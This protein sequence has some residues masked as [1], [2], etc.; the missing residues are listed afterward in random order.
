MEIVWLSFKLWRAPF[1]RTLTRRNDLRKSVLKQ[2]HLEGISFEGTFFEG[3][4][5]S[6]S[7]KT[8]KR[9]KYRFS[10]KVNCPKEVH[11]LFRK[12]YLHQNFI[13]FPSLFCH[14]NSLFCHV[15]CTGFFSLLLSFFQSHSLFL[16]IRSNRFF[17]KETSIKRKNNRNVYEIFC[18]L[19]MIFR[20]D[21]KYLSAVC[22][23]EIC[24]VLNNLNSNIN[25]RTLEFWFSFWFWWFKWRKSWNVN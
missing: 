9:Q 17:T 20:N 5:L 16:C 21:C 15:M 19:K 10:S 1:I 13:I 25:L 12:F 24:F 22:L 7:P 6:R 3:S 11:L 23:T 2:W 8:K 14:Y 18:Q 4:T